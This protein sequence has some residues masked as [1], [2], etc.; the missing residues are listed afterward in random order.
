MTGEIKGYGTQ[1]YRELI[2]SFRREVE[3]VS[4]DILLEVSYILI[5]L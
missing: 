3:I 5:H 1:W 4:I 2:G